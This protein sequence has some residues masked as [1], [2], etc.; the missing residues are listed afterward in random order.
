MMIKGSKNI[1]ISLS[2]IFNASNARSIYNIYKFSYEEKHY[3]DKIEISRNVITIYLNPSEDVEKLN[4][5]APTI[6]KP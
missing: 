2:Q 5:L 4:E 1:E 3:S 6:E